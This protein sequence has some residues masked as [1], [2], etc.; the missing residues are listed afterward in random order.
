M[1]TDF[2][3]EGSR[4]SA[5]GPGLVVGFAS[6][7][8]LWTVWFLTHLP[9]LKLSD[10]AGL[11]AIGGVWFV[12]MLA[13]GAAGG[14]CLGWKVGLEAGLTSAILGL[15]LLG[16]TRHPVPSSTGESQHSM[17]LASVGFLVIGLAMGVVG[18]TLGGLAAGKRDSKAAWLHRFAF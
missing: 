11:L 17:A 15:L 5:L 13:G 8:G 9:W 2:A 3:S 1:T 14:P 6:A 16:A 10:Q 12:S 18:C 4:P 7:I